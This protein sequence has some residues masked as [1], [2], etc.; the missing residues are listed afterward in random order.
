MHDLSKGITVVTG[1]AGLIGSAVIWGLNQ[2]GFQ[3][4]LLVDEDKPSTPKK[5][6][7]E[8]LSFNRQ[9]HPKLF[10][11]L[12]LSKSQELQ[13]IHTIIH[14][15][16]LLQHDG[17]QMK[18]ILHDNNLRYTTRTLCEWS[19]KPMV[20]DLSMH[21]RRPP[22]EMANS[23]GWSDQN[24]RYWETPAAQPVRMVKAQV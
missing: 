23:W 7:L 2:K 21:H 19:S 10:R 1:G 17:D 3:N 22:M 8:N 16:G 20:T 11:K 4:I 13:D 12:V 5:K 24:C 6:N 9:L 15:G 14:L 18:I